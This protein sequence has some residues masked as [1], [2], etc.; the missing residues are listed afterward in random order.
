M[1]MPAYEYR[2]ASASCDH[3]GCEAFIGDMVDVA[4]IVEAGWWIGPGGLEHQPTAYC[5][6]HAPDEEAS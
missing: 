5:P 6:D 4:V 1:T 2:A 3:P